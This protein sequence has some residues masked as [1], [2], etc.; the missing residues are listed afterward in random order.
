MQKFDWNGPAFHW[1]CHRCQRAGAIATESDARK[2]AAD[3]N[4]VKHG[5]SC[6]WYS[7]F[8]GEAGGTSYHI[9]EYNRR[10]PKHGK[11]RHVAK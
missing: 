2:Q 8:E 9:F 6:E 1:V 10:C 4:G 5:C 11:P 7:I 3:H